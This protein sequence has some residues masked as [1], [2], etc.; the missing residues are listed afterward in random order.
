MSK[1]LTNRSFVDSST[2]RG[3]TWER[4]SFTV[5]SSTTDERVEEV[6]YKYQ[7]KIGKHLEAQGFTVLDMSMP[8]QT[9]QGPIEPDRKKYLVLS[10][11]KRRPQE[12]NL[13]V[14]DNAVNDMMNLGMRLTE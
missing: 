7:N 2:S 1:G 6:A 8:F 5:P 3:Y 11:V 12:I 14:P 9:T 13:L 4:A 10:R